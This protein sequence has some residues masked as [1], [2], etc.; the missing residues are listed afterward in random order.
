MFYEVCKTSILN[1]TETDFLVLYDF[2]KWP[3]KYYKNYNTRKNWFI[4][5]KGS[6]K[7][8]SNLVYCMRLFCFFK[9]FPVGIYLPKVNN[10]NIKTRCE[11]C[12][13]STIKTRSFWCLYY[14]LWI[15]FT[16]CSSVSI[17]NVEH[18]I[19]GWVFKNLDLLLN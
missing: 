6:A 14:W 4:Q 3:L 2:W 18:V 10:R 7:F 19:A 12:S 5:L 1:F 9:F 11:I 8:K 15:Y 13:K 17:V 16:S